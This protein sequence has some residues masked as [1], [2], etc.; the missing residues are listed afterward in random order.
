MIGPSQ[1]LRCHFTVCDTMFLSPY[2]EWTIGWCIQQ[3]WDCIDF[4]IS[5]KKCCLSFLRV[6]RCV[7]S[8]MFKW[9]PLC[10]SAFADTLGSVLLCRGSC[11]TKM[12]VQQTHMTLSKGHESSRVHV[13]LCQQRYC[14]EAFF[15]KWKQTLQSAS[16]HCCWKDHV[17]RFKCFTPLTANCIQLALRSPIFKSVW[18]STF[19]DGFESF[20]LFFC[21]DFLCSLIEISSQRFHL[22]AAHVLLGTQKVFLSYFSRMIKPGVNTHFSFPVLFVCL[23]WG[24]SQILSLEMLLFSQM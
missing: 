15:K 14:E 2:D 12:V 7:G 24:I 21:F 18:I 10:V 17:G 3:K 8:K 13:Y 23:R 6:H 16:H 1:R 20:Q 22:S 5:Q 9:S 19:L 11:F 4:W